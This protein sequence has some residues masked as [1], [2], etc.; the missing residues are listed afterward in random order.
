MKK[1]LFPVD[2]SLGCQK[3]M[4]YAEDMAKKFDSIITILY[5]LDDQKVP[6]PM[7]PDNLIDKVFNT[8]PCKKMLQKEVEYFEKKGVKA[9][10]KLLKGDPASEIIDEAE[11]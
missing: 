10:A 7:Q 8:E 11:K 6:N 4:D 3:A 9:V 5:V 1:I 2:G